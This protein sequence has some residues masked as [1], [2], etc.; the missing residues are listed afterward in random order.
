MNSRHRFDYALARCNQSEN[1]I[2][3][4]NSH[5]EANGKIMLATEDA[6]TWE[7]IEVSLTILLFMLEYLRYPIRNIS[8]EI[9]IRNISNISQSEIYPIYPNQKYIQ[10]EIY[11]TL[12][13]IAIMYGIIQGIFAVASDLATMAIPGNCEDPQ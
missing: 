7:E 2:C 4:Q 3:C 8:M 1:K 10:S 12:A 9:Y 11:P 6:K 5:V 13:L